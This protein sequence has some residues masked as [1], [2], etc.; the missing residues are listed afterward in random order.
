MF[1]SSSIFFC[2][3]LFSQI[4][5]F[6]KSGLCIYS[7]CCISF[8][9]F[10]SIVFLHFLYLMYF[11][12]HRFMESWFCF[13]IVDGLMTFISYIF[14]HFIYPLRQFIKHIC[15]DNNR[16]LLKM[17]CNSFILTHEA[18]DLLFSNTIIFLLNEYIF[19]FYYSF[20]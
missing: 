9:F 5:I 18:L 7:L 19:F 14:V 8:F 3:F 12:K 10:N 6:L 11:V 1:S 16:M 13:S 20:T 15:K 4:S 17:I 2:F